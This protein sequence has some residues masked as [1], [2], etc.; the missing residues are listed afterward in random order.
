MHKA[1]FVAVALGL[2]AFPAT[3]QDPSGP[4]P[5]S[6]AQFYTYE[7]LDR[8]RF[9]LGY[10]EHLRW[11]DRHDDA[12]VW[13]AW[14]VTAGPRRGMFIDG[15]AGATF[16][17]LDARPDPVADGADFARTSAPFARPVDVE[18]W[19]LWSQPS[20]GTP[21]EDRRPTRTVDAFHLTLPPA[22]AAAFE[23]QLEAVASTHRNPE[24]GITWYR[25]VRGGSLPAYLILV[26]RSTWAD[27]EVLGATLPEM[28]ARA[29]RADPAVTHAL[30][31]LVSSVVS[32]TWSYD[33]RLSLIPGT[34]LAE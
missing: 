9:E 14:T 24:L 26:S 17:G 34:P 31:G 21:L 13:Y 4:A 15:T 6:I 8:P 27:V 3:A 5:R 7:L 10:R 30:L 11:H 28:L 33:P 2:C 22:A 19:Q 16:A 18:T 25:R 29:Y 1:G 12:L 23:R 20:T 32:E